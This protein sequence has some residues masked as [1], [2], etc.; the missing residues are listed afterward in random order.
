MSLERLVDNPPSYKDRVSAALVELYPPSAKG[1]QRE[2]Y[3]DGAG[4][5]TTEVDSDGIPQNRNW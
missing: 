4:V 5:W 3:T 1:F 2:F